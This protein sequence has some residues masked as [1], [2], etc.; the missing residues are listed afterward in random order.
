VHKLG[1]FNRTLLGKWLW[2][3]VGE[4][5]HLWR[6]VIGLKYGADGGG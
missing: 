5:T 3:F 6:W 1:T 2:C 4:E